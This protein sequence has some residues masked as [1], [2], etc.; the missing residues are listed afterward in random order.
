[1]EMIIDLPTKFNDSYEFF[2]AE[3]LPREK[4]KNIY[5]KKK[6]YFLYIDIG[7]NCLGYNLAYLHLIKIEPKDA[8]VNY[9]CRLRK[10]IDDCDTQCDINSR[11][12]IFNPVIYRSVQCIYRA[13]H[14]TFLRRLLDILE[15]QDRTNVKEWYN[16][17]IKRIFYRLEDS[18]IDYIA[19]FELKGKKE[20]RH[21]TLISA[22]PVFDATS[23][24]IYDKQYLSFKDAT[25]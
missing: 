12:N 4:R 14:L 15:T 2:K 9:P 1:M 7:D 19:I 17:K 24:K 8:Y 18:G 25:I 11:N 21:L 22:F 13:N 5:F 10:P 23:K 16:Y 6:S 3:I 20:K